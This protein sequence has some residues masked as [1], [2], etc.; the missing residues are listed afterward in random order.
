MNL[1]ELYGNEIGFQPCN[2]QSSDFRGE[3]I[4]ILPVEE[5][6]DALENIFTPSTF[7]NI[8][9]HDISIQGNTWASEIP[10]GL[11][12]PPVGPIESPPIPT[13]YISIPFTASPDGTKAI[14]STPWQYNVGSLDVSV[15]E[16][17][18]GGSQPFRHAHR[19]GSHY[20]SRPR[21]KKKSDHP[22][23]GPCQ[24][25]SINGNASA[26]T[27]NL[28]SS[29]DSATKPMLALPDASF[30]SAD[31][32]AQITPGRPQSSRASV[33]AGEKRR[34]RRPPTPA[35][36]LSDQRARNRIAATRCR[37][38]T[39]AAVA[40][41]EATER[42]ISLKHEELLRAARSLQ[43]DVFALKSE[44]LLHGGCGDG[45]IQKYLNKSAESLASG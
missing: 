44:I 5:H 25:P 45:L 33:S 29:P 27:I 35:A 34:A 30:D 12:P 26:L 22:Q 10:A 31:T 20:P 1:P 41:L 39:K 19:T 24:E 21:K 3:D 28:T 11:D 15:S 36:S 38:K 16:A 6:I 18:T 2:S 37:M 43:A 7:T 42:K 14:A 4:S 23:L 17:T 8:G 9:N 13:H 32:E 40:E